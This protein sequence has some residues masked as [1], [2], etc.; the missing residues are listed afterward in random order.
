[1]NRTGYEGQGKMN[2]TG[3][4]NLAKGLFVSAGNA[5]KIIPVNLYKLE[6]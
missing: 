4:K 3:G 1:M 6:K 5:P 2:G